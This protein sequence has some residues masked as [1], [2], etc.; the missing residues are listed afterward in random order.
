MLIQTDWK[1]K[2]ALITGASG[3][4]G[5]AVADAFWQ[6]GAKLLLTDIN[7][8]ALGKMKA[9]FSDGGD[10]VA[11]ACCDVSKVADCKAAV[12]ASIESFG[13][14]DIVVNAAGV[15]IKGDPSDV[16]EK[17]W[18]WV[19]DINLK[20]TFFICSRAIPELKKTKGC[21]VNIASDAGIQGQADHTVYCAG[22]GG[23]VNMTRALALDLAK[24]LVRV[25]AVC[26]SD[27]M[28]PMLKHEALISGMST[29]AYHRENLNS[30]PQME[31]ARY[32]QPEEIADLILYL[33]SNSARGITGAA[34]SIDYGTSAGLW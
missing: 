3:G 27:I 32:L 22:K 16:T 20:G 33:S 23:V 10:R 25:N 6:A 7:I 11:I 26:P 4:V 14:L 31:N 18:D 15:I 8:E 34:I 17:Q 30:Y 28:T 5:R 12:A 29:E 9:E 13:R 1:E 19:T 21:I 24:D 2:V